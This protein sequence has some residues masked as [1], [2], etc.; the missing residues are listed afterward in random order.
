LEKHIDDILKLAIAPVDPESNGV[1]LRKGVP[2]AAITGFGGR[3]SRRE[4]EMR[5]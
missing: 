3:V 5:C 2:I 1:T 4:W